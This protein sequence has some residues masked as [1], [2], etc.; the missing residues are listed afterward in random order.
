MSKLLEK[1]LE[2]GKRAL[3]ITSS[4]EESEGLNDYLW[5]YKPGSWLPHG[6][7]EDDNLDQLPILLA[8]VSIVNDEFLRINNAQ[9][10]FLLSEV[11]VRQ[12]DDFERCFVFIDGKIRNSLEIV[13]EQ[14]EDYKMQ[15][16]SLTCWHETKMGEWEK[17]GEPPG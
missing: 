15:H 10:L 11:K 8:D 14:W 16:H 2:S 17:K 7:C 1:T 6:C 5:T 4:K 9:F 3:L 12:I 13:K